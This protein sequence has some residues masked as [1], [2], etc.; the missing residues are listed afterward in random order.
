MAALSRV[1]STRSMLTIRHLVHNCACADG[2]CNAVHGSDS[3]ASAQRE[4]KFFFPHR[5]AARAPSTTAGKVTIP[6]S[7]EVA[8]CKGLTVLARDKPSQD[9]MAALAWLGDWLLSNNPLKPKVVAAED[10]ALDNV[11]DGSDFQAPGSA[12]AEEAT[13]SATD[14]TSGSVGCVLKSKIKRLYATLEW[15]FSS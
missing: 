15:L 13:K 6:A 10:L 3:P 9:P 2:T 4:I 7:L 12:V 14:A 11:D 5:T 1:V 8:L